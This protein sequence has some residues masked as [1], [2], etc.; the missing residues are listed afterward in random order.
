[1]KPCVPRLVSCALVAAASTAL[2]KP[3]IVV[4]VADDLGYADVGFSGCADIPTPNIDSLARNGMRF[5][6]GYVTQTIAR[7]Q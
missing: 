1:M 7:D 3:N 5:S 6:N 2:A 4:I